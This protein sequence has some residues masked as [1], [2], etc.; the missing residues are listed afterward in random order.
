[1]R[2]YF[3]DNESWRQF[4]EEALSWEGTPYRHY[5]AAKKYGADC[6]MFIGA[7]YVAVGIL[8]KISYEYYSRD[9]HLNTDNPVV[10]NA[11][12]ENFNLNVSDP[13]LSFK[14]ILCDNNDW[15]RGD[16]ALIHT[17]KASLANHASI[18]WEDNDTMLHCINHHG[19]CMTQY[20]KWWKRHTRYKIRLFIE[21]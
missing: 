21:D 9:W 1:M 4:K 16:I 19:V 11:I 13:K 7:V 14:K 5:Q 20:N 12:Q 3:C 6:T 17:V 10:E 8:K 15:V 2:P 18:L